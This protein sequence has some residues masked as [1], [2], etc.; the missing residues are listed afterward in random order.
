MT[1]LSRAGT[2]SVLELCIG[3]LQPVF[4]LENYYLYIENKMERN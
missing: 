4:P 1:I 3:D 2:S